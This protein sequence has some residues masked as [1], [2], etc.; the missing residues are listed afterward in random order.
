[1]APCHNR[2]GEK[3][4]A[5][6]SCNNWSYAKSLKGRRIIKNEGRAIDKSVVPLHQLSIRF[7]RIHERGQR[8]ISL[9]DA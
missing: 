8:H 9:L 2:Y 5:E 7:V 1:M 4:L 3:E 6:L